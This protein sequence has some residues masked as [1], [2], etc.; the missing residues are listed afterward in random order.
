MKEIDYKE[1]IE[2]QI[3]F[4]SERIEEYRK[5]NENGALNEIIRSHEYT[6]S[7]LN[8]LLKELLEE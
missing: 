4:E 6:L 3:R 8:L 5:D 2:N 1:R 7:I